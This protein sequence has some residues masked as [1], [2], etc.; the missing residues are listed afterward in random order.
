MGLVVSL[1]G[2]STQ[3]AATNVEPSRIEKSA[4]A[5]SA[6]AASFQD[7]CRTMAEAS[8]DLYLRCA[9]HFAR[10]TLGDRGRCVATTSSDCHAR[11]TARGSLADSADL[12]RC[13]AELAKASCDAPFSADEGCASPPGTLAEGEPCMFGTQCATKHCA[14]GRETTCGKCAPEPRNGDPCSAERACSMRHFCFEGRCREVAKLRGACAADGVAGAPACADHASCYEGRCIRGA[15]E[16][17][18][19]GTLE[20]PGPP[21]DSLAG[22][23]CDVIVR[24]CQKIDV[25]GAG[26]RCGPLIPGQ[27]DCDVDSVCDVNAWVC[28]AKKKLGEPCTGSIFCASG[29]CTGN[30]CIDPYAVA[31]SPSRK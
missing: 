21:C 19:C 29:A 10:T 30:V 8:C 20:A 3:G 23:H 31:C 22:L 5:P 25:V 18:P 14:R 24:K 28:V 2:C 1:L 15:K 9:P 16:G 26:K 17:E 12:G 4:S 11:V 6:D 13:T 27:A 7:A